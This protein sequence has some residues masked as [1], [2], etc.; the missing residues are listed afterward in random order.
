[1]KTHE[2]VNLFIEIHKFMTFW[3]NFGTKTFKKLKSR[4]EQMFQQTP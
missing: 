2:P 1:M 3:V 4:Q